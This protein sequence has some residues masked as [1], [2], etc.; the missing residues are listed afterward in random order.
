MLEYLFE[1]PIAIP[2]YYHS[3]LL[4]ATSI[5][6]VLSPNNPIYSIIFFYNN[7]LANNQIL[8]NRRPKPKEHYKD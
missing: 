3:P 5:P 7:K 2:F 1:M 6:S 8:Q 4:Q